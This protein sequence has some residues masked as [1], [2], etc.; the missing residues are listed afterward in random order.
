[1]VSTKMIVSGALVACASAVSNVNGDYTMQEVAHAAKSQNQLQPQASKPKKFVGSAST[2][3]VDDKTGKVQSFPQLQDWHEANGLTF[4]H[5]FMECPPS[6]MSSDPSEAGKDP[7]GPVPMVV[8]SLLGETQSVSGWSC[9]MGYENQLARDNGGVMIQMEHRFFGSSGIGS[10]SES[11]TERVTCTEGGE[12]QHDWTGDCVDYTKYPYQN[13]FSVEYGL[14]DV[15]SF[16]SFLQT[17]EEKSKQFPTLSFKEMYAESQFIV[18]GG[19]YPGAQAAWLQQ[20]KVKAEFVTRAASYLGSTKA[21]KAT[22]ALHGALAFSAP[23][24]PVVYNVG[25]RETSMEV[26]QK[27]TERVFKGA[28]VTTDSEK[29]ELEAAAAQVE[30]GLT[31]GRR[32]IT[33]TGDNKMYQSYVIENEKTIATKVQTTNYASVLKGYIVPLYK[34]WLK[35]EIVYNKHPMARQ[36]YTG[37]LMFLYYLDIMKWDT[38]FKLNDDGTPVTKQWRCIADESSE[39]GFT[40]DC[41]MEIFAGKYPD[42]MECV[43]T[44]TTTTTEQG[45]VALQSSSSTA[46]KADGGALQNLWAWLRCNGFGGF[47]VDSEGLNVPG[48]GPFSGKDAFNGG[49]TAYGDDFAIEKYTVKQ[50]AK[51]F[52]KGSGLLDIEDA[53]IVNTVYVNGGADPWATLSRLPVDCANP[54][55]SEYEKNT[56]TC[57]AH[58]SKQFLPE[59]KPAASH[60]VGKAVFPDVSSM[61]NW[62]KCEGD[63]N[64]YHNFYRQEDG[65]CAAMVIPDGNKYSELQKELNAIVKQWIA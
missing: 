23:T 40:T 65:H 1:M 7:T 59:W 49:C 60:C 24:K 5:T 53:E 37:D 28:G 25:Y 45:K 47:Q 32:A 18:I 43:Q 33:L 27:P 4:Q 3:R 13:L 19:S 31:E 46:L 50:H 6:K 34:A 17:S 2:L 57:K 39:E 51:L 20:P 58:P 54:N 36:N 15:Y 16:I 11:K 29:K 64:G 42:C 44:Q 48:M 56:Y 12:D 55:N 10:T 9:G 35:Q 30:A 52:A 61:D 41:Q 63:S 26:F 14:Y 22:D 21:K 62:A 38:A 8:I